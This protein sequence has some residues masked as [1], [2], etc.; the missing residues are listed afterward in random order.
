M[1]MHTDIDLPCISITHLVS[2]NISIIHRL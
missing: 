2:S 1:Y